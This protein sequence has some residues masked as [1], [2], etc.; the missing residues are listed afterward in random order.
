M[1]LETCCSSV[2]LV[3]NFDLKRQMINYTLGVADA[4]S[5]GKREIASAKGKW[6]P[7]VPHSLFPFGACHAGCQGI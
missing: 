3:L 7:R 2:R 6:C 4:K 1:P 5:G